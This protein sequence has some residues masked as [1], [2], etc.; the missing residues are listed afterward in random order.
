MTCHL[1]KTSD[2]LGSMPKSVLKINGK[3]IIRTTI[4]ILISLNIQPIVC[5]GYQK[6]KII[7]SLEGLDVEYYFNPFFDVTNNIASI[8]FARETLN[9]DVIVLSADVVFQKEIIE[10][11]IKDSNKL[12]MVTDKTRTIDGDYFFSL[13]KDSRI[14]AYGPDIPVEER[15]CEYI[16]IA[17][18]SNDVIIDFKNRL[19]KMIENG[20]YQIYFEF[21]FFSY[22]N[23]S[24]IILKTIDVSNYFW[25][26]IDF[27]E[28]YQKALS[29]LE[30]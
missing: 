4:E 17:K 30:K 6:E 22:I 18:I 15:S 2:R 5:V 19:N 24:N 29:V 16:G 13:G 26:E 7:E 3:P 8:W 28:D 1:H 14:M 11:L 27:Y 25:R 23:D 10:L 9:E 20:K 21:V 12:I